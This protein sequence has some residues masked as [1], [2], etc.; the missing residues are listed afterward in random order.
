MTRLKQR[1]WSERTAWQLEQSGVHPLLARLYAAR[2][3]KTR[4]Q[5]STRI[6]DLV[7]PGA[8]KGLSEA[9]TLLA[10]AIVN[11]QR[12]C[13]VADYDA[14]GAT[15]CAVAMR[16]L[17]LLGARPDRLSYF[18]PD[19]FKLGYGL[20]PA[21]V[22]LV[23]RG[24]GGLAA[25]PDLL[26]TV[27]NG[28]ASIDGVAHAKALGIP[29]VI[30]DHHLPGSTLPAAD[31]IVNPNQPGCDFPS[32]NLAGVGVMFYTL[33]GVRQ[34]LRQRG[35]AAAEQAN[36]GTLLDLVALGTIADVVPLDANNRILVANGLARIRQRR[37]CPG[38][39]ALY[40]VAG[41]QPDRAQSTDLGFLLGPRLNAAGRMDDMRIGIRC[42]L[43]DDM[44]D[45]LKLAQ[46]LDR[47]N[48]ARRSV[49]AQ[50]KSDAA[51]IL[52]QLDI[53]ATAGI[54][55]YDPNW[56]GGVVGILAGR[57]K[58][59]MHRPTIVFAGD[60]SGDIKGSGRSIPGLHLRDALDL[61]TKRY[62]DLI[63][64][65]GGHAMAAGLTIRE[66]DFP[67]FQRAFDELVDQ[68]LP[69]EA[70]QH[71]LAVDGG[72][73]EGDLNLYSAR[74]LAEG[75]WGQGFPAPIFANQFRILESRLLQDKH[76]KLTVA[77]GTQQIDAIR[78]NDTTVPT[79]EDTLAYG[80]DINHYNGIERPQLRIEA[81]VSA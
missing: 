58:E 10:D 39:L 25:K 31:A 44:G 38:I 80:L 29:V 13:V 49:E 74:L 12:L 56:H 81:I 53:H 72:L 5:I 32:K 34:V 66:S 69:L 70:R 37:C 11:G 59:Q 22:D 20:T 75:I 67:L 54:S 2:G 1:A 71:S 73:G 40:A 18:V 68:L 19:R 7:P 60:G 42:L 9:A 8:L 27:D 36:L 64:K 51:S 17:A 43:T 21:I 3:I 14:D 79:Q 33:I 46:E 16:G 52:N 47:L 78:F 45:A 61:L 4:E 76:L 6:E 15:A 57:I 48:M 26:I 23:A 50:M 65:F 35:W 55:L 41:K 77:S 24:S 63:L 30:T 28:I 62:P